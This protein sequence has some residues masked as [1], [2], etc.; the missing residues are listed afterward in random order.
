MRDQLCFFTWCYQN[1]PVY[2][3]WE[4]SAACIKM[5]QDDGMGQVGAWVLQ[6]RHGHVRVLETWNERGWW[7]NVDVGTLE[8]VSGVGEKVVMMIMSSIAA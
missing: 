4:R 2:W 8:V 3:P 6:V 5:Q 1:P 7:A